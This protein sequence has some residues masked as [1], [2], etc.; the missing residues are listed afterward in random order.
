MCID[1]WMTRTVP[2]YPRCQGWG[3][4]CCPPCPRPSPP[5]P[6]WSHLLLISWCLGM[7]WLQRRITLVFQAHITVGN[8][9]MAPVYAGPYQDFFLQWIC[10]S[11]WA[12]WGHLFFSSV[13][14]PWP[15]HHSKLTVLD[16]FECSL[17]SNTVHSSSNK[18][19]VQNYPKNA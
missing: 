10:P 7:N 16:Y 4:S 3:R 18:F 6:F 11:C 13:N 8:S 12:Y 1:L 2:R 19:K 14:P 9:Q 15:S 5:C 17:F